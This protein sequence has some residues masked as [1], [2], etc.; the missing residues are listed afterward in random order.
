MIPPGRVADRWRSCSSDCFEALGGRSVCRGVRT[1]VCGWRRRGRPSRCPPTILFLLIHNPGSIRPTGSPGGS[2]SSSRA[3]CGA[4]RAGSPPGPP[5]RPIWRWRQSCSRSLPRSKGA[6]VEC[7]CWCGGSTAN[8]SLVCDI[9]GRQLIVYDSFEGLPP[10]EARRPVREGRGDR[11][12][13]GRP[14]AGQ[15]QRAP[16]RGDRALHV[17][18]GL[19]QGHAPDHTEPIVALLPRRRLAGEPRTIACYLWPHLTDQGYVFIDEYVLTDYCALFWSERYW[20]DLLRHDAA[21]A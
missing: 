17:P 1:S 18:Q 7:G 20:R 19:V 4:P 14:R 11:H 15:G 21:R 10:P 16:V 3:G 13:Q 6:V 8:L 9:V 5:T 12:A 2:G